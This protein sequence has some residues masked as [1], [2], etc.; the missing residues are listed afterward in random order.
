[1]GQML[2]AYL[3]F[4][5]ALR[6]YLNRA[7]NSAAAKGLAQAGVELRRIAAAQVVAEARIDPKADLQVVLQAAVV[8]GVAWTEIAALVNTIHDRNPGGC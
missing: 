4:D 2:R 3:G 5:I 1:M 8:A 6:A 7:G